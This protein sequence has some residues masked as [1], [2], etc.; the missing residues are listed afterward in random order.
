MAG[1]KGG[2]RF[3]MRVTDIEDPLP[4]AT[5]GSIG[6]YVEVVSQ[7]SATSPS[8]RNGSRSAS[9]RSRPSTSISGP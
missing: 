1:A 4:N 3:E 2:K 5:F 8:S 7:N 6:R 9:T